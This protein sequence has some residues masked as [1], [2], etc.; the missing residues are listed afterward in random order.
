[1]RENPERGELDPVKGVRRRCRINIRE[2]E[3]AMTVAA[4]SRKFI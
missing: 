3:K 2:Q 1:M 4:K